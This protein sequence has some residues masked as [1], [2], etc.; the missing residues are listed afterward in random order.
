[1]KIDPTLFFTRSAFLGNLICLFDDSKSIVGQVTV[2]GNKIDD[3]NR[4]N[5]QYKIDV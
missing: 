1:M 3:Q 4:W 5:N 2:L